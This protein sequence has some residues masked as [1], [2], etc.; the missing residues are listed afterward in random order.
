[1]KPHYLKYSLIILILVSGVILFRAFAPMFTGLL[2]AF[3][4]YMLVRRQMF[5][6]T[7]KKKCNKML[8]AVLLLF[9]VLLCVLIPMFFMVWIL[10]N[11]FQ[12]I[13][14]DISGLIAVF[15]QKAVFLQEHLNYDLFNANNIKSLTSFATTAI[16][17]VLGEISS[18]VINA[19]VLLFILYFMLVNGRKMEAYATDLLPFSAANKKNV[20]RRIHSMVVSNAIGIPLLAVVQGTVAFIGYL[21][22]GVPSALLLALIT[23]FATIIPLV[24][25]A[26]VWIPACLYLGLTGNWW[27]ALGLAIYAVAILTNVDNV[28]RF[29]LQKKMAN[30]HP[31]I[32]V[33]GVIIGISL[34]GFWGIIFG[35]LFL[36][37]FFLCVNIFKEEY[38]DGEG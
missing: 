27:L 3:T 29:F 8:I 18:F 22:F 4:V 35:P 17:L 7:E 31:L 30:T 11:K 10:L 14:L 15:Q 34:F 6:F 5:F 28:V 24:G 38:L 37:L 2:G 36:S 13:D 20:L 25:T 12:N 26:I 1:M 32:T 19:L 9:E 16:Q 21:I 33:F 23:C